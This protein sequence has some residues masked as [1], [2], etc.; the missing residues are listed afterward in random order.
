[1][2]D[3]REMWTMDKYV[4]CGLIAKNNNNKPQHRVKKRPWWPFIPLTNY[5]TPL[6][7]YKIGVRNIIFELPCDIIN[8]CIERYPPGEESIRLAVS[9]LKGIIVETAKQCDEW[10]DLPDG[11]IWKTLQCAVTTHQKRRR[12]IVASQ[13]ESDEKEVTYHSNVI[14]LNNLQDFCD[15]IVN[16]L[17][18]AWRTLAEQQTELNEMRKGRV[19]RQ[20]SIETKIFAVLK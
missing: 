17:K 15:A 9:A 8:E 2:D 7:H 6:L 13:E 1:M 11:N 10:D 14:Q 5:V 20:S 3:D 4:R 18:K 16:K 12:L 19:R